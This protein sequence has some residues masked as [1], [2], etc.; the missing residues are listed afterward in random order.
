MYLSP[1]RTSSLLCTSARH[2]DSRST[3]VAEMVSNSLL[4][5]NLCLVHRDGGA[6]PQGRVRFI[7]SASRFCSSD[8]ARL[9][10]RP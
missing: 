4:L 6:L 10:A 7:R 2:G 9:A 3:R 5:A 1:L 8:G